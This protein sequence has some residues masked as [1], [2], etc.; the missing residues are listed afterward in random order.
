MQKR[1]KTLIV[2]DCHRSRKGLQALLASWPTVDVIGEACDGEKAV[3]LVES[4][5]PDVVLMDVQMPILDG[6][7]TT[8]IIKA[9]WSS[10]RVVIITMYAS[11]Q[12]MATAA[13]ADAFL[14]KGCSDDELQKAMLL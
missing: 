14:V 13:G 12:D 2:D 5:Q 9:L 4:Q 7:Q 8:Q 1:V 6:I 11:Y 3:K 10:V